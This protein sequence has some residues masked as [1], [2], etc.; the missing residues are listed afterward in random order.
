MPPAPK[1]PPSYEDLHALHRYFVWAGEMETQLLRIFMRG[2][3]KR[4]VVVLRRV[5]KSIAAMQWPPKS[6]IDGLRV[7]LYLSY[8]YAA[9]HVVVEG[10]KQL[11]LHDP[12]VDRLLESPN[13]YLLKKYRDGVFHYQRRYYD[14][15][16][17][18]FI[19]EGA[20]VAEWVSDLHW[21]I[22]DAILEHVHQA[23]EQ[24]PH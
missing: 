7:F 5:M 12:D 2:K 22:G 14:E 17:L 20:D 16:F 6:K 18:R 8:W 3:E 10:W 19:R 9:L 23:R 24:T 4:T 11:H 21:K 13:T 1:H 15:R